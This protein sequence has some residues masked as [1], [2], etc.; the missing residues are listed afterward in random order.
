MGVDERPSGNRFV[1][2]L[3][4]YTR[5]VS[6]GHGESEEAGKLRRVLEELSPRDPALDRADIEIRRHRV[7]Q[8]VGKAE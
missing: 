2:T 4:E 3:G 1:Q 6:D 5:L 8:T 7:M